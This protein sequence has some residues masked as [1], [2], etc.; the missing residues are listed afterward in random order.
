M[1]ITKHTLVGMNSQRRCG[2]HNRPHKQMLK[3]SDKS[4][5]SNEELDKVKAENIQLNLEVQQLKD[6]VI[7]QTNNIILMISKCIEI[8]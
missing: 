4:I 3:V 7:H 1:K 2:I 5:D 8:N 6:E